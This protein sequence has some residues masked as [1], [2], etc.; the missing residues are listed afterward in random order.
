MTTRYLY[1]IKLKTLR[2]ALNHPA[3]SYR[4]EGTS[5]I[6]LYQPLHPAA[7]TLKIFKI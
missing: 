3:Y 6:S 5:G 2:Y 4:L 7:I 1:K